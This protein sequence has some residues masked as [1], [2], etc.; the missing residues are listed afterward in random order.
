M[1][2]LGL[3]CGIALLAAANAECGN[4]DSL[5]ENSPFGDESMASPIKYNAS[6][7]DAAYELRGT[8]FIGDD[9]FFSIYSVADQK[10]KWVKRGDSSK[11]FLVHMFDEVAQTLT[12]SSVGVN[13]SKH[14][15]RLKNAPISIETYGVFLQDAE[16]AGA[17]STGGIR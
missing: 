12:F 15:V 2:L 9:Q 3:L 17:N 7:A 1:K 5:A 14:T 10:F 8:F 6:A 4:F 11:G 16:T 13:S